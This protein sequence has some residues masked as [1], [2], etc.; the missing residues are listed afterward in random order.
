[1]R[2]RIYLVYILY[3]WQIMPTSPSSLQKVVV[4]R[5]CQQLIIFSVIIT[6]VYHLHSTPIALN[7][8][9]PSLPSF[10]LL[11]RPHLLAGLRLHLHVQLRLQFRSHLRLQLL[12][13]I[14]IH[15]P[16][17]LSILELQLRLHLQLPVLPSPL[18]LQLRLHRLPPLQL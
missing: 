15:P 14:S 7:L 1:M 12:L 10:S 11:I 13:T 6:A 17:I 9:M 2:L 5:L 4:L 16:S 3:W 18:Q 8:S